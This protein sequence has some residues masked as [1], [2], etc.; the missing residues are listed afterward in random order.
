V[1]AVIAAEVHAEVRRAL[2]VAGT[3]P[4]LSREFITQRISQLERRRAGPD[5]RYEREQI[6]GHFG[7]EV[8]AATRIDLWVRT[9]GGDQHF[10]EIKSGKPNKGQCIEMKA[11]LL[12]AFAIRRHED[13]YWGW[14]VPCNPY[15][16]SRYLHAYALP[17]FDFANKVFMGRQFWDFIGG[18]GTYDE[19]LAM[20][21]HVGEEFAR[22]IDALRER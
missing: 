12:T 15:G 10:F 6:R 17:F 14:G 5:A 16:A 1:A 13:S 2:D 4:V 22:E 9:H 18:I 19:L 8:Q 3:I 20:Y 21:E 11:R 7:S